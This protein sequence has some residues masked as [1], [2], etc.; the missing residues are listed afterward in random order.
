MNI[1]KFGSKGE[2]VKTLQRLLNCEADGIFGK[3]T[4]EAVKEFQRKNNLTVDGI[5]GNAT[6]RALGVVNK[7]T[8]PINEI[9]LHCSATPEGKDFT[10]EDI[11]RW[12]KQRG[13]NDIG[14]HFV[15]YRDGSVNTG[16]DINI[17]GAHATGHNAN[18][19]GICYIGGLGSDGKT[20]KDTRTEEQKTALYV[21]V[22]KLMKQ[23]NI[24]LDNVFGHYQFAN[25]A[26]PS[27]KIDTFKKEFQEWKNKS[28]EKPIDNI[29][30]HSKIIGDLFL[31]SVQNDI[32][33][34]RK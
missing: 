12:H 25:K 28:N 15:I 10:V 17:I 23:Y 33:N 31:K 8:R 4:D 34:L 22:D 19:I 24:S 9:I 21:L 30:L 1:L 20:P 5:V 14:Y 29:K 27:F 26:C 32:K 13:F 16:R 7:I 3:I 2:E 11:R 18:S 6:W